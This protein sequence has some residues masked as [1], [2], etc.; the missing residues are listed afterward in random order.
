MFRLTLPRVV[1]QELAGSPLRLGPDEAEIPIG[2]G[3]G[4]PYP[5][6]EVDQV[7]SRG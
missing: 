7:A 4:E 6:G 1:G 3:P 5:P 2:L